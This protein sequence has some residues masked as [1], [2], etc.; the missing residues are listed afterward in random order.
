MGVLELDATS[1]SIWRHE[2]SSES[3]RCGERQSPPP[4]GASASG[5][6]VPEL[7]RELLPLLPETKLG[8][9]SGLDAALP[10]SQGDSQRH[11]Y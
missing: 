9:Q 11:E 5:L 10:S 3:Y 6:V 4:Q 7:G 1:G 2:P 8:G